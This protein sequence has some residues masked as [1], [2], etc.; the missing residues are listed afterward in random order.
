MSTTSP[1]SSFVRVTAGERIE[2]TFQ[3][4][5]EARA[6]RF[7][8]AIQLLED[9]PW[10][11]S[12]THLAELADTGHPQ[13]ARIALLLMARGSALFGGS[14]IATDKQRRVWQLLAE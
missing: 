8:D 1:H 7:E 2:S 10:H 5:S 13:A 14:F 9:G 11:E 4:R 3:S 6:H 12:F